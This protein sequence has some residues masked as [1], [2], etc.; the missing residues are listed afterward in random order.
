[1]ANGPVR[2]KGFVLVVED[3]PL[4]R[5]FAVAFVEDAGFDVVEAS[6]ANQAIAILEARADI[7][8]VFTDIDMPGSMDG[9]KLA[10]AVRDRWPSIEIIIV[11]GHK[12]PV[13][14][15]LRTRAVFF[16]KPYDVGAVTV[17]LNRMATLL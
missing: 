17:E 15:D 6:D 14:S 7:R 16:S 11:S 12:R 13:D 9:M 4:V 10:R 1:M 8:I 5:M 3:E 2:N